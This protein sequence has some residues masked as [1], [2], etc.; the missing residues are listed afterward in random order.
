MAR[1]EGGTEGVSMNKLGIACSREDLKL[2]PL[3][4]SWLGSGGDGEERLA[5]EN[6][7]LVALW[8]GVC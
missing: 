7:C 5:S 4:A 8:D 1:E 3:P 6:P 2:F